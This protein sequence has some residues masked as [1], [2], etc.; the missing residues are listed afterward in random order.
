M[1]LQVALGLAVG[2]TV[3]FGVDV[4]VI[5]GVCVAVAVAVAVVVGVAVGVGVG[6]S[7][8]TPDDHFA[9]GPDCRV[10]ISGSRRV[11]A[12]SGY[13]TIRARIVSEAI[14]LN[15]HRRY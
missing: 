8:T 15:T 14:A 11:R 7:S 2:V 5:V 1:Q 3:E 10:P 9:A 13:P 4:G 12:T 6:S